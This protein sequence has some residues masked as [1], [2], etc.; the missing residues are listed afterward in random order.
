[1]QRQT[2]TREA[3]V[4]KTFLEYVKSLAMERNCNHGHCL[5]RKT[6]IFLSLASN[7]CKERC[8]RKV[9]DKF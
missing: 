5:L 6:S 4:K 7:F 8:L 1:M 2:Q 3:G 9:G